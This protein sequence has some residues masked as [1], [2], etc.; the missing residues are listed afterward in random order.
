MIR[1]LLVG[2]LVVSGTAP[3]Q[4][5]PTSSVQ[6]LDFF[7]GKWS[8]DGKFFKS[9]KQISADASF[10]SVLNGKWIIFRHDDRPPFS[11]HAL[12]E[13]GWDAKK[14]AFVSTI[15]DS[16]GGVRLFRSGGWLGKKLIWDGG[17]FSDTATAPDQRFEFERLGSDQFK[18]TY[19]FQKDGQWVDVDASTCKKSGV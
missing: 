8:C 2:L 19:S 18:V 13:W 4:E 10:E 1:F 6:E 17:D 12:A 7:I 11:Y 15:Q 5:K 14:N 16:A 3:S 9:G